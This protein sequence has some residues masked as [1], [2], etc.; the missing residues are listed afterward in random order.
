MLKLFKKNYYR[1]TAQ[2]RSFRSYYLIKAKNVVCAE[3][4]FR[5]LYNKFEKIISIEKVEEKKFESAKILY[6]EE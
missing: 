3:I 2:D 5:K 4:K 1:F 6:K